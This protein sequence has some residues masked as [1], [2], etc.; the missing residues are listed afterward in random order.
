MNE[1][2]IETNDEYTIPCKHYKDTIDHPLQ[3]HYA[4]LTDEFCVDDDLTIDLVT[5]STLI[6]ERVR[7]IQKVYA[8]ATGDWGFIGQYHH[9][10][11]FRS[12]IRKDQLTNLIVNR[13]E[14][15]SYLK[16]ALDYE[17]STEYVYLKL[18][19]DISEYYEAHPQLNHKRR[20]V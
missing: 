19:I 8:V 13:L 5:L 4:T 12:T 20:R 2:T 18:S 16:Y 17:L 9:L 15:P 14:W 11:R 6:Q 1:Q 10:I 3:E 7:Y